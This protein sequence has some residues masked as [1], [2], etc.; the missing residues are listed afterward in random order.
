MDYHPT[1]HEYAKFVSEINDENEG[2]DLS[3]WRVMAR[4]YLTYAKLVMGE[5]DGITNADR[6]IEGWLTLILSQDTNELGIQYVAK[7]SESD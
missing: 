2:D 4:D 6:K 3:A 5:D 7:E 1:T